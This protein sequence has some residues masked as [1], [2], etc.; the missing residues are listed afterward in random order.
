MDKFAENMKNLLEACTPYAWL[1]PV[2][3]LA[4]VGIALAIPSEKTKN[5]AKDHW[6]P[7]ILGTVIFA[8]C[9]YMGN[10]IAGKITF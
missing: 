4:V 1:L 7:V 9:I 8:G 2:I 5:F 6:A 10:W 3:G